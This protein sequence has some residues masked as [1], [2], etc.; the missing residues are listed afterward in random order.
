MFDKLLVANRSEIAR[1][2][3]RTARRMGI[4]CVAVYS[5]ADAEAPFVKEADEAVCIGPPPPK[6]SYLN[7]DAIL[8]A[9]KDTGAGAI[10]P[11]YGFLSESEDLVARCDAAGIVFVGPPVSA[12]KAMGAKIAAKQTMETAGVPVVPWHKGSLDDEDAAVAAAEHIGFP[13]MLKTSAGGGGIGMYKCK[14]E[15]KLRKSFEDARK[16][17][18]MFFGSPEVFLEKYIESPHHIEVQILADTH[19]NVLHLYE[20]ECSVQ[21]RHQKLVEEAPSPFLSDAT[22]A[23]MCSTA[24]TAARAVGYVGAG[25]V[26]MV[27]DA[28]QQYFFLEMNTRLQVEHPVTEMILGH[29]LVELQ[30][31]VAAGEALPMKQAD[32]TPDGHAIELRVCA[33]DPDKRFFPSPGTLGE[34][35]WPEGEG[36]RVDA[37]VESGNAVPQFYDSLIAKIIGHGATRAEAIE[38]LLK[39]LEST[40]VD[41]VATTLDFHRRVLENDVFRAGTYDTHFIE[42]HLGLK[43]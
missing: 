7:V 25:T 21:R 37:G 14:K 4:G 10:H 38:R 15:K 8:K 20:R 43:S 31:R 27:V 2:V 3:M 28:D 16:K 9:A 12:M 40:K 19:G 22:R 33:E 29:D 32:L 13:V 5:E 26:E 18:E 17:G 41:G 34:V 35:T 23:S 11:G 36:V 39:A 6:E 42:D 24:V 30:L 1:R